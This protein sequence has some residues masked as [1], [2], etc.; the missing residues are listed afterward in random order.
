MALIGALQSQVSDLQS[1]VVTIQSTDSDL[2]STVVAMQSVD[3][4]VLSTVAAMQSVDSAMEKNMSDT[5]ISVGRVV[6]WKR[7]VRQGTD[8]LATRRTPRMKLNDD[9]TNDTKNLRRN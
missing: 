5:K 8:N 4:D 9:D 3:S 2:Q 6:E 7:K 1:K